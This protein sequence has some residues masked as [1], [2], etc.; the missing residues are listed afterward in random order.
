LRKFSCFSFWL[1]V[2][3]GCSSGGAFDSPADFENAVSNAFCS[4][5]A[6]CG[7]LGQSEVKQCQ[8][9]AANAAKMYKPVYSSLDAVNAHRL[10]YDS[11][12]A[13]A[14]IDAVGKAGC[15]TDSYYALGDVCNFVY[16]GQVAVGGNCLGSFECKAGNWCDQG[17]N[18]G[19]TGCSGVCTANT[20]TGQTCDANNPHC[21][22]SDFCDDSGTTAVCKARAKVGQTCSSTQRCLL[23]LY[24]KG[25]D[26]GP[27]EVPGSCSDLAKEGDTCSTS[28]I[29]TT[30]CQLGLWCDDSDPNNM[31]CKKPIAN[32]QS[33]SSYYACADGLDCIG[34]AFDPNTGNLTTAGKCGPFLDVGKSCSSPGESGCPY[35]TTCSG[36]SCSPGPKA[37]DACDPST[38]NGCTGNTYC[39]GNTS[40]CTTLVALGQA[41]MNPPTDSNGFPIGGEPCHDGT[42]DMTT[43][44]CALVCQ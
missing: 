26:Q 33:C 36:G 13:Q 38:T 23:G 18:N 20:A 12:K 10:S 19:T 8:T 39:D 9:D 16:R 31:T 7:Y 21:N 25:Y 1:C 11:G 34:V 15:S 4:Y 6:R 3:A 27:P 40:K 14:C 44:K 29:G 22:D 17:A 37:G 24:C 5:N 28:F 42:C 30:N 35:D 43:N 32:G 41:C 2:V